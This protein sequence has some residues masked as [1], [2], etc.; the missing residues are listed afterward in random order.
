MT[1]DLI[2]ATAWYP[3]DNIGGTEIY[4]SGLAEGLSKLG[5]QVLVLTPGRDEKAGSYQYAGQT[6]ATYPP[7]SAGRDRSLSAFAGILAQHPAAIYHQHS[8][9]PDCGLDHLAIAKA[10]GRRTVLTVHVPSNICLRGTMMRFGV[11]ACDGLI[12]ERQ[13]APCWAQ[14][15][16]APM[17]AARAIAHVPR[18]IADM[19][20]RLGGRA[21][22]AI[23]TRSM[24]QERRRDFA[25]MVAKS[26]HIVAVCGWLHDALSLN[27]VAAGK[28]TLSR[29]G[30]DSDLANA[31]GGIPAPQQR[32]AAEPLRMLYLGRWHPVKGLDIVVRAMAARPAAHVTLDIHAVGAG[33]EEQAYKQRVTELAQGDPRIS[34]LPPLGREDLPSRLR[35]YNVLVIPSLWLETG[36][37]VALEAQAARLFILGSRLGGVAE[38][39]DSPEKGLLVEPGDVEAWA[40]A[41]E[42]LA[43]A[44]GPSPTPAFPLRTMTDAAAEMANLHSQLKPN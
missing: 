13:C 14:G 6:V 32:K 22:T 17:A 27:G 5:R 23:A 35:E 34:I 9:T 2:L 31:L 7:L 38:L 44:N 11:E 16:G 29:Q 43:N 40:D 42:A 20:R 3:P 15:R 18:P 41:I 30:V 21:G 8:W 24:V 25:D 1:A 36:P 10:A 28:L 37:L 33:A 12:E 19:G 26:D 39:V 4:L